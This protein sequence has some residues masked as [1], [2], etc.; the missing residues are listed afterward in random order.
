ME[1]TTK[2]K[3]IKTLKIIISVVLV[4]VCAVG[5]Y[6][7]FVY[8]KIYLP[9]ASIPFE[10]IGLTSTPLKLIIN[11]G[12]PSEKPSYNDIDGKT[13]YTYEN[14][15]IFDSLADAY[16]NF[17]GASLTYISY[18]FKTTEENQEDLFTMLIKECDEKLLV[19]NPRYGD[20]FIKE[21]N[22]N[23]IYKLGHT[24]SE[25]IT[26]E[27]LKGE[28]AVRIEFL[29]WFYEHKKAYLL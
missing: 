17:H 28:V 3:V 27:K 26:I 5:I 10:N 12:L 1:K 6:L 11:H 4:F 8:P 13:S 7:Q 14:I 19:E 18:T 25:W 20:N 15:E 9:N 29:Y 2:K 24:C 22:G 21:E 23:V 16:Y